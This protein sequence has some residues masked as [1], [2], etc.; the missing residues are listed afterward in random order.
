MLQHPVLVNRPI[1]CTRKGVRLCRPRETVLQVLEHYP[2]SP[3]YKG[4]G[5]QLDLASVQSPMV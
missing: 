1:V 4:D 5:E 2:D 3:F